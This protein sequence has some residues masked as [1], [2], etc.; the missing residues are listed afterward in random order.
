M[1]FGITMLHQF[2]WVDL[3]SN[4]VCYG[5]QKYL[6]YVEKQPPLLSLHTHAHTH[7]IPT[8]SLPTQPHCFWSYKWISEWISRISMF[9]V[10]LWTWKTC[11]P[12]RSTPL[13]YFKPT[14]DFRQAALLLSS[15]RNWERWDPL[16][17][18]MITFFCKANIN[19]NQK[20]D[21]SNGFHTAVRKPTLSGGFD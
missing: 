17:N 11:N 12:K 14:E 9:L 15:L 21:S 4:Y 7:S 16:Q 6:S 10:I 13:S 19:L 1:L 18:Y 3:S 20:Y 5:K 8:P 2:A